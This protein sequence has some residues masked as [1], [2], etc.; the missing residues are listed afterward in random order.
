MY[1]VLAGGK[2]QKKQKGRGTG[3]E[4]KPAM[5]MQP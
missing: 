4:E 5:I 3:K 1:R 2:S